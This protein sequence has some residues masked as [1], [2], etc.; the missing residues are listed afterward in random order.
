MARH[1]VKCLFCGETFDASVEPFVKPRKNRYAH[2]KC[3]D[4]QT[5]EQIQEAK[6]LDDLE[7]YIM[8]LFD[9]PYVNQKT[10]K[11]IKEYRTKYNY[12]YSGMLK[13]LIYWFEVKGNSTERANGGIGIV[14]YIYDS[15][16]QYYYNLFLIKLANEDKDIE[17]YKP[18][19]KEI[20][21]L[22]PKTTPKR[23]KLFFDSEEEDS[24]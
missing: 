22:P 5:V 4:Q 3:A 8:K 23:I 9:E 14:P 7:Q 6:D 12:T 15:A 1:L 24:E 20:T 21:I 19:V 10:Q 2:V 11:Q 17:Q 16:Y 18:K 13:S